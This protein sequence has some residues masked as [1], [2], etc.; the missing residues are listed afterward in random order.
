MILSCGKC[1]HT[2]QDKKHGKGNRVHV[3]VPQSSGPPA[4]KC[5][6][7]ESIRNASHVVDSKKKGKKGKK[8]K[9]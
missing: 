4:W 3:P 6:I 2:F 1:H 5:T 8:G 9:K 7:C